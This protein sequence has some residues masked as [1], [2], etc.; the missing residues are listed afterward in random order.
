MSIIASL[1]LFS[2]AAACNAVMDT[3]AHHY[4]VSIF[5]D[6]KMSF[7]DPNT[8]WATAKK[9][10]GY[11]LDA[12]HLFKSSMIILLALSVI[13]PIVWGP[14]DRVCEWYWAAILLLTAYGFAWNGVFNIFYNYVLLKKK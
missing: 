8:S 5:R 10:F 14:I 11:K 13:V 12:W 2:M 7:W 1:I 3:L 4:W 9:I 6:K